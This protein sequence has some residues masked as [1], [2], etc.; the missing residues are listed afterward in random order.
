MIALVQDSFSMVAINPV[1]LKKKCVEIGFID[2]GIVI[3]YLL[4]G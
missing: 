3:F 2:D 1:T 4:V